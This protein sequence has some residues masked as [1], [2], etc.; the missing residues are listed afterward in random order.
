M[1]PAGRDPELMIGIDGTFRR[2]PLA[3]LAA[4]TRVPLN[5]LR[6]SLARLVFAL[7]DHNA[8]TVAIVDEGEPTEREVRRFGTVPTE[9]VPDG[10][11]PGV[12]EKYINGT[13][14]NGSVRMGTVPREPTDAPAHEVSTS[15][16]PTDLSA[17]SLAI[18][19]DDTANIAFYRTL[20]ATTAPA[21]IRTALD[22]T[23]A[24]REHLRGPAGAYFT[25]ITRRLTHS[26][27]YARTSPPTP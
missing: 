26:T 10:T 23:L 19:L 15:A 7:L 11:V 24:R 1:I 4:V 3:S 5:T 25:A 12:P 9:P 2:V 8:E 18:T 20:V 21:L 22:E 17:E 13:V 14:P 6:D 16:T 27:P